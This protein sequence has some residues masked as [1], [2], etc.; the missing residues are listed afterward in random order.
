MLNLP[1]TKEQLL[2][3]LDQLSETEKEEIL[4]YIIQGQPPEPNS[5]ANDF[6]PRDYFG[7]AHH[8]Q[9]KIDDDLTS[10][11]EDWN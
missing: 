10:T 7:V 2:F 11:R 4:Q 9:Q 1:I 8:T 6:K 3:L 5:S